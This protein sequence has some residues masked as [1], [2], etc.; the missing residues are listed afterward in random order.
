MTKEV[1]HTALAA[2]RLF[3][4]LSEGSARSFTFAEIN[5][6]ARWF[7]D[8]EFTMRDFLYARD[9][10]TEMHLIYLIY[11][12]GRETRYKINKK[13]IELYKGILEI[14]RNG[15]TEHAKDFIK[16]FLELA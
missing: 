9:V 16:N 12:R 13:A 6:S 7:F 5:K 1:H 4:I 11:S 15:I 3:W 10:L 14:Q 8:T 2:R